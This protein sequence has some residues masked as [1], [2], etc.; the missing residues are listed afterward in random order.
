MS[1]L[2]M[3]AQVR[4]TAI[5]TIIIIIIVIIIIINIVVPNLAQA[6]RL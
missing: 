1:D 6:L 4:C 3:S 5:I 2:M